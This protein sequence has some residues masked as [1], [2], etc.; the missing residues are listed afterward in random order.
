[1][2]QERK[3]TK[4]DFDELGDRGSLVIDRIQAIIGYLPYPCLGGKRDTC[5]APG[6]NYIKPTDGSPI[7]WDGSACW[8][9]YML[10]GETAELEDVGCCKFPNTAIPKRPAEV[11][12]AMSELFTAIFGSLGDEPSLKAWNV[13]D[14]YIKTLEGLTGGIK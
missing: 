12:K 13:L 8:K 1:M 4:K 6:L 3:V 2:I 11:D 7:S 10:R 5:Y 9:I 14:G